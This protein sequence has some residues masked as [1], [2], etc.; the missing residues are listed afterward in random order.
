MSRPFREFHRPETH[1]LCEA[2]LDSISI[3]LHIFLHLTLSGSF[4]I[5]IFEKISKFCF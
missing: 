3:I 2:S 1:L 5:N 4:A